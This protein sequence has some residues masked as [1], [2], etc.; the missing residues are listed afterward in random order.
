MNAPT[1]NEMTN[2]PVNLAEMLDLASRTQRLALRQIASQI[3]EGPLHTLDPLDLGR[4]LASL[5]W[6]WSMAPLQ[7]AGVF[8]KYWHKS[9]CL[10]WNGCIDGVARIRSLLV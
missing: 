3:E 6:N 8:G 7:L 9:A 5:A 1:A 10:H 2:T 4:P